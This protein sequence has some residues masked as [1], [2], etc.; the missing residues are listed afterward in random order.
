MM[1]GQS[2]D[3]MELLCLCWRLIGLFSVLE[4]KVVS[5]GG[6]FSPRFRMTWVSQCPAVSGALGSSRSSG[7]TRMKLFIEALKLYKNGMISITVASLQLLS[8]SVVLGSPFP[9]WSSSFVGFMCCPFG[10]C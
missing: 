9:C 6:F 8:T 2:L 3:L 4:I 5:S 1:V 10:L 7:K